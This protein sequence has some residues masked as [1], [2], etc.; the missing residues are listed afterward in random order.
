MTQENLKK[1]KEIIQDFFE[2]TG[3]GNYKIEIKDPENS[4]LFVNLEI[5]EPKA[6]IGERGQ[7]LA[8]IQRL[9]RIIL[10]KKTAPDQ[11]FYVDLDINEYKKNKKDYLKEIAIVAADEVFLTKKEKQLPPMSA[12][13]RKVVH[14]ELASRSDISTESFGQEPERAVIIKPRF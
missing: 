6:L 5:D 7:T 4:T 1:I 14:T 12:F 11:P 13:E 3:L 8:D 2:K 10:Q 9:L